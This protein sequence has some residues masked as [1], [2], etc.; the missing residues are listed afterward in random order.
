[1]ADSTLTDWANSD[2][3]V[4]YATAEGVYPGLAETIQAFAWQTLRPAEC[5]EHL[6]EF[7]TKAGRPEGKS[8]SAPEGEDEW[9]V[10]ADTEVEIGDM[11][12]EEGPEFYIRPSGDKYYPRPWGDNLTDVQVAQKARE[13]DHPLFLYGPP[14]TGKTAMFEAAFGDEL[15]TILGTG[16]TELSDLMGSYIPDPSGNGSFIWQ[17]GPLVKAA[18]EGRPVLIDEIGV[19][20]PKVLTG[21]YSLMDG[22]REYRVTANP[23]RG[24]VKAAPG[25]FIVAATNPNAIG[26]N[27][28]EALL[29]RFDLQVEVTTDYALAQKLGVDSKV[30]IISKSLNSAMQN[31]GGVS[32][33][34]QFR[35]LMV[36]R[37]LEKAFGRKFAIE[38]LIASAPEQDRDQIGQDFSKMLG[39]TYLPARI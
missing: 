28:S 39:D 31:G 9:D 16:D 36:Y 18:V 5:A 10:D 37:D 32:W 35:E 8:L 30:V 25:F 1:M 7:M 15:T 38:N 17:D 23:D 26:V 21:V 24:V 27:L 3:A 14:G 12:R 29:S 13:M 34:P 4:D 6:D 22:R 11:V 19:I 2:V 20:N 33:A